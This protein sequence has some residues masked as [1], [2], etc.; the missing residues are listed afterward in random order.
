MCVEMVAV[1]GNWVVADAVL[2]G[3]SVVMCPVPVDIVVVVG[4]REGMSLVVLRE[5]E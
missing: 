1:V 3:D 4:R 5:G 2:V